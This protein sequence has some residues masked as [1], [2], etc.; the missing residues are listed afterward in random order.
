MFI[1]FKKKTTLE[2]C[3]YHDEL[4]RWGSGMSEEF[5]AGEETEVSL[6][7]EN[8]DT[9]PAAGVRRERSDARGQDERNDGKKQ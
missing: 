9:L 5:E 4:Q 2:V 6:L 1:R 8:E 7:R 3:A